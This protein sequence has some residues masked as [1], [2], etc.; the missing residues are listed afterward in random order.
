MKTQLF[1]EMYKKVFDADD[2]VKAC[3]RFTCI[4]L[5]NAASDIE[6]GVWFGNNETG[7]MCIEK[8]QA[9]HKKIMEENQC[10]Q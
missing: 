8:L 7:Y 4:T 2:K 9:L 6:E 3:G 1:L 5:I 10:S